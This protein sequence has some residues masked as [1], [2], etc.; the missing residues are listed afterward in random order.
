MKPD[1][2]IYTATITRFGVAPNAVLMIGD[3]YLADVDGPRL[4]GIRSLHLNRTGCAHDL[5]ALG[6]LLKRL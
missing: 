5:T 2:E 6:Q 3:N 4:L 1:P